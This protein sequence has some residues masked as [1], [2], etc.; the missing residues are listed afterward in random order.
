VGRYC[1]RYQNVDLR[2]GPGDFVVGRAPECDLVLDDTLVS[3]RHAAFRIVGSVVE[4]RD[5][6]S[7]N[8][9]TVNQQRV[10]GTASLRHGDRVTIGSQELLLRDIDQT[11]PVAGTAELM[12]CGNCGSFAPS[13]APSCPDCGEPLSAGR[14]T[15][16]SEQPQVPEREISARPLGSLTVV[17]QL[18]DKALGMGR[19]E[20]AERILSAPL[21]GLLARATQ[22]PVE[23]ETLETASRCALR[24]AEAASKPS[25]IDYVFDVHTSAN[26]VMS[27]DVIEAL[28]QSTERLRYTTPRA[29]RTYLTHMRR[30]DGRSLGPN[31]R[32]LLQR[33]DGL[34]RR[35]VG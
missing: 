3:R 24:L 16:P 8:G 18:A 9:V 33:L 29:L 7:R 5:L 15:Q 11:R 21:Q 26:A 12:R 34:E 35:I 4:L 1:L 20:E 13:T 23:A 32:F 27:G 2:L 30:P 6:E 31:E 22:Q 25:W 10:V 17:A 19:H 14:N 28:Y